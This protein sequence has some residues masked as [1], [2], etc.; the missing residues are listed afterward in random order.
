MKNK[1]KLVCRNVAPWKVSE[2]KSKSISDWKKERKKE[3]K[4][5]RVWGL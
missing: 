3:R 5:H 1:Q 4:N 2:R